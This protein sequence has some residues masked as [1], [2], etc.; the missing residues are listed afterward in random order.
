P[1]DRMF[2]TA[3]G[4]YPPSAA[5]TRP[6]RGLAPSGRPVGSGGGK[7]ERRATCVPTT[8]IGHMPDAQ[9]AGHGA[10]TGIG[11]GAVMVDQT[12]PAAAFSTVIAADPAGIEPVPGHTPPDDEQQPEMPAVEDL[13]GQEVGWP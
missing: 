12:T 9:D 10:L 2:G 1:G 7:P 6:A 4:R 5:N 13:Y 3:P 8:R 11:T